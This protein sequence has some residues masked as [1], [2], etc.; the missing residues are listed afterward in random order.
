MLLFC[1]EP[2][3]AAQPSGTPTPSQIGVTRTWAQR[4]LQLGE[5]DALPWLKRCGEGANEITSFVIVVEAQWVDRWKRRRPFAPAEHASW[6]QRRFQL[7]GGK[8]YQRIRS[9][10]LYCFAD[11]SGPVTPLR[12]GSTGKHEPHVDRFVRARTQ[13]Q[14]EPGALPWPEPSCNI[15]VVERTKEINTTMHSALTMG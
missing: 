14:A 8:L 2:Q 1:I 6:L 5:E 15:L 12:C 7:V 3:Q 11:R 9:E 10:P 4:E 13:G